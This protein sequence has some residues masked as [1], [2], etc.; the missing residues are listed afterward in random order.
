MKNWRNWIGMLVFMLVFGMVFNGCVM[1]NAMAAN[2]EAKQTDGKGGNI[3]VVNTTPNVAG[4]MYYVAG[5]SRSG[6]YRT[7]SV[8][9]GYSASFSVDEDGLY[10][11]YYR[12]V[13]DG[14]PNIPSR[15][16]DYRNW[17][18]KSVHVSN[19]ET[20]RVEIP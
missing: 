9:S 14:E 13:R 5:P 1:F 2:N 12:R 11:I 19:D 10:L 17:Y 6:N 15:D 16:E 20:F 3:R 18:S 7:T 4:N 8:T